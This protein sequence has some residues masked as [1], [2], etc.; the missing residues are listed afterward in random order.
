MRIITI[1]LI[2]TATILFEYNFEI[3]DY[4][5]PREPTKEWWDF[6]FKV[7]SIMKMLTITALIINL[8]LRERIIALPLLVFSIDDVID[9][10]YF[11]SPGWHWTDYILITTTIFVMVM[12]IYNYYA[13]P[14]G[15]INKGFY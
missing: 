5:K 10:V 13:R 14:P 15:R 8:K 1:I 4:Y 3:T 6:R 12:L 7:R 2:I 11:D 9:R